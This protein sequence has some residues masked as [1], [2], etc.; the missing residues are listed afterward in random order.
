MSLRSTPHNK[1]KNN[2]NNNNALFHKTIIEILFQ[3]L[4]LMQ[5][6][7]IYAKI[8]LSQQKNFQIQF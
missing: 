6:S 5:K 8:A 2:N 1:N 4:F 3:F 7:I